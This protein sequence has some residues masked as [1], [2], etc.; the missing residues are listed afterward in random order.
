[1]TQ[2]KH[3]QFAMKAL[4]MAEMFKVYVGAVPVKGNV[5][6]G[7]ELGKPDGPSTGGGKQSLQPIKLIPQGDG[8]TLVA[9]HA[10]QV[11]RKAELRTYEFVAKAHAQRF[12]GAEFPIKRE[13]YNELLAKLEKFFKDQMLEV[14]KLQPEAPAP[15]EVQV[16]LP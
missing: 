2:A 8:T 6:Y 7:V 13:V 1:M 4:D 11:E 15:A 3:T 12:P 5:P 16:Q 14:T 9:G 10:N